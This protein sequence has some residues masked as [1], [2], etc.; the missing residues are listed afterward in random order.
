MKI[1]DDSRVIVG[2]LIAG[3]AGGL[4]IATCWESRSD[5]SFWDVLTA[6][7]T[8]GAVLVALGISLVQ[9]ISLSKE[10]HAHA[11][12][13]AS[14]LAAQVAAVVDAAGS[15]NAR[16]VF[17]RETETGEFFSGVVR[18]ADAAVA[19]DVAALLP[20]LPLPNHCA[21]R[22]A[23][24]IGYMEA[25]RVDA[26]QVGTPKRWQAT[27]STERDYYL[28]RWRIWASEA[29]TLFRVAHRD[30]TEA[31]AVGVKRPTNIEIFGDE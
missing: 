4:A 21:H 30:F 8:L 13:V 26:A 22:L 2:C 23:T 18:Q 9:S 12:L 27:L 17:S 6:L 1:S 29:D 15:A 5:K 19:V 24:A 14:R 16:L 25:I 3:F 10:R 20:L 11:M 7:G 31:L 28:R